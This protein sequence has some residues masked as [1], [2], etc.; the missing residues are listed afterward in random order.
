MVTKKKYQL[1][2]EVNETL[3]GRFSR[4]RFASEC[5]VKSVIDAPVKPGISGVVANVR[6]ADEKWVKN[7]LIRRHE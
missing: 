2:F 6:S 5:M 1:Q 7:Q 3:L 4:V